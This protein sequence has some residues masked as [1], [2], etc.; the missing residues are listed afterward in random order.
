MTEKPTILRELLKLLRIFIFFCLVI[1]IMINWAWIKGM[2]NY[3]SIY[4]DIINSLKIKKEIAVKV[5]EIELKATDF[6]FTDKPNSIEIPK[7]DLFTPLIFIESNKEKDY[8]EALKKGAVHYT[9]S[10]LPGEIGQVI[11][12]G[13]SAPSFWP[14]KDY[15]WI[16]RRLDELETGDEIFV[17]YQNR[18]YRYLVSK[19]IFLK[20]GEEIPLDESVNYKSV[21]ILISCWPPETGQK[22]ILVQAELAQ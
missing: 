19:K 2:F 7:I 8:E 10:A 17:N 6:P 14:K 20:V 15:N 21:L 12:L 22:R 11:V 9:E 18:E 3:K 5:P 4:G 13:H 16:F 1:L